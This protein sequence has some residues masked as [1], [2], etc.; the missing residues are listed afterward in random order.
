MNSAV[1][2][3]SGYFLRKLKL[4][5]HGPQL[6]EIPPKDKLLWALE[7]ALR[8]HSS[9]LAYFLW[10][11]RHALPGMSWPEMSQFVRNW[12]RGGFDE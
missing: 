1:V 12:E 7:K 6:K 3:T 10:E 11:H 9:D 8:V 4:T 2:F 5:E